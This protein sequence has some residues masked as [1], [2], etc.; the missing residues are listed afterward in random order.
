MKLILIGSGPV[1]AGL[2]QKLT[3]Q[4]NSISAML[5][6]LT[7]GQLDVFEYDG[8]VA[9]SAESSISTETLT[10]VAE[11]GR[12]LYVCAAAHDSVTAWAT[13]TRV[14]T[15]SYPPSQSDLDVLFAQIRRADSGAA[16][17]E[18]QYRR[19]VI[20]GDAAAR[21]A[22]NMTARKIVVT[23]PKG[24]VGKTTVAVNLALLYALSGYSTYL[25]DAD[26]NGGTM[27][28]LI[29]LG[30]EYRSSLIQLLRRCASPQPTSLSSNVM[31]AAAGT[32]F[33][34][35]TPMPGLPT[36]KVLPGLLQVNDLADPAIMDEKKVQEVIS[37]LYET[38]V[39]SNGVVIMDVGINPSHPIHRAA[40]RHAEAITIV[41]TPEVSDL[42]VTAQWIENL[43]AAVKATSSKEAAMQFVWQRIKLC[44]N[45]VDGNEFKSIH[46]LMLATLDAHDISMP[47]VTNGVIPYTD[48]TLARAGV[49]SDRPEDNL[50]WRFKRQ[51]PEEI[52]DFVEALTD[53][54]TQFTPTIRESAMAAG[55]LPGA[56]A[57]KKSLFG[58]AR[59]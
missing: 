50:I 31:M 11:R 37:G 15:I 16:N 19:V 51:R 59:A 34:A 1:T 54:A 35:F 5:G 7:P 53:L 41:V 52:K 9:V 47:L 4:G 24:G 46:K 25:V 45:K 20:G 49:N 3:E 28:Y 38:G 8:V 32:F 17:A 42:G 2:T 22:S 39:A 36:L 14:P 18:D 10:K 48:R 56:P 26:G 33:D 23:S 29:K 13:A 21:I 27:S 6:T 30:G 43:L 57:R 40:L 58:F 55:L 12:F 44:Y